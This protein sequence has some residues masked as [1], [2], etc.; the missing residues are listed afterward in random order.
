MQ[1]FMFYLQTI[2][3]KLFLFVIICFCI[4]TASSRSCFKFRTSCL[5]SLPRRVLSCLAAQIF[6]S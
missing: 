1:G 4:G 6:S 5:R 2:R 3:Q